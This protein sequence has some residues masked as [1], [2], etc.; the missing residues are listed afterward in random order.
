MN[1]IGFT[2]SPQAAE[3]QIVR[4]N[5][6]SCSDKLCDGAINVGDYDLVI[7]VPQVDGALA[8]TRSLILSGYAEGDVIKPLSQ[9]QA[10]L[11]EKHNNCNT[12]LSDSI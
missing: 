5:I 4:I 11:K 6:L 12:H 1:R 8:A 3:E 9:L 7:P 2:V 10:G